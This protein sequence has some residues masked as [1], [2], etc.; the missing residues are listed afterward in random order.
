MCKAKLFIPVKLCDAL[1]VYTKDGAE[2]SGRSNVLES[3]SGFDDKGSI[4]DG[5]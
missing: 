3:A 4:L 2:R 5:G 1:L